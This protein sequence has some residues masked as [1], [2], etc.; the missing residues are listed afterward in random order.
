V[1]APRPAP[2]PLTGTRSLLTSFGALASGETVAR[3]LGGVAVIVMT[4]VLTP[5]GFG[6]VTLGTA[7]VMGFAMIAGAGTEML[8][9]SDVSRDPQRLRKI[10]EPVLALRLVASLAV[11]AVFVIGV[12]ALIPSSSS[13]RVTLAL[14]AVALPAMALNLRWAVLGIGASRWVGAG[15]VAGQLLLL[16]GVLLFVRA[17]HDTYVV[18]RSSST[19]SS[20][21]WR[22]RAGSGCRAR[23][24][25]SWPGARPCGGA[26]R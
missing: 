4:R 15:N 20:S 13:D 26:S 25:T 19:P 3:L 24:W 18:A 16:V 7:L 23:T 8:N 22:W 9:V 21:S 10:A 11:S 5:D 1:S 2:L 17:R 6:L 12:L 14:F